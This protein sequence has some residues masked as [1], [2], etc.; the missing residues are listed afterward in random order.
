V[1]A[2][3]FRK[4]KSLIALAV[5]ASS[6]AALLVPAQTACYMEYQGE[7]W[8]DSNSNQA[9]RKRLVSSAARPLCPVCEMD[10]Y[11]V[12]MPD[13]KVAFE[14]TPEKFAEALKV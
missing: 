5:I 3:V 6:H 10:V 13:H 1:E 14:A 8:T 2:D 9:Y 7:G 4:L 11:Y 12:C